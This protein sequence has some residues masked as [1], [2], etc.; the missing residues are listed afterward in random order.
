MASNLLAM[1][2]HVEHV[3]QRLGCRHLSSSTQIFRRVVAA[4]ARSPA[5]EQTLVF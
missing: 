5:L 1:V 3:E 4:A 2:E